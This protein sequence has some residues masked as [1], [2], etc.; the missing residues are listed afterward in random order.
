MPDT[1]YSRARGAVESVRVPASAGMMVESTH[2][3]SARTGAAP[4]NRCS[5]MRAGA[6]GPSLGTATMPNFGNRQKDQGNGGI[7]GAVSGLRF[8]GP[9]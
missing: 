7:L 8:H 1:V 4:G 2:R 5:A 6:V 9:S 3:P